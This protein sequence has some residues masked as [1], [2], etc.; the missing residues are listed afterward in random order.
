[1]NEINLF[2]AINEIDDDLILNSNKKHNSITLKWISVAAV[3]VLIIVVAVSLNKADDPE[4]PSLDIPIT[5]FSLV[6]NETGSNSTFSYFYTELCILDEMYYTQIPKSEYE[7]YGLKD[8]LSKD[9]FGEYLGEVTF[10]NRDNSMCYDTF[11]SSYAVS[12]NVLLQN[13]KIYSY[14]PKNCKAMVVVKNDNGCSIYRLKFVIFEDDTKKDSFFKS[15]F[16]LY[17]LKST[18]AIEKISYGYF[19]GENENNEIIIKSG[20]EI[21]NRADIEKIYSVLLTEDVSAKDNSKHLVNRY[22]T[23]RIHLK[24][25]L[26]IGEDDNLQYHPGENQGYILQKGLLNE[27]QNDILKALFLIE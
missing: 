17:N 12:D 15:L 25:G 13:A 14:N 16:E 4:N 22:I 26:I 20:G 1:M 11:D 2:E 8:T 19:G 23:I 21:T 18:S 10:M 6:Q 3:F 9:D 24:N 7:K 5:E 27:E